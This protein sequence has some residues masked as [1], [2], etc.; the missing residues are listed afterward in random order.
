MKRT[1]LSAALGL[2]LAPATLI[3]VFAIAGPAA[4]RGT[5]ATA[6]VTSASPRC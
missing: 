2:S 6:A 3:T 5:P 4:I 1:L